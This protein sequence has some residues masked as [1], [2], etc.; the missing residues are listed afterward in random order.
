M[1]YTGGAG[2]LAGEAA[3]A[4]G[5]GHP[6]DLAGS[7]VAHSHEVEDAVEGTAALQQHRLTASRLPGGMTTE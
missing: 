2:G 5:A 1:P 6:A 7:T 3:G 4:P